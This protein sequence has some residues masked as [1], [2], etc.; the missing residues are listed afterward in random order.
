MTNTPITN[1]STL[2]TRRRVA[3]L[4]ALARRMTGHPLETWQ[5]FSTQFARVVPEAVSPA[6]LNNKLISLRLVAVLESAIKNARAF[7]PG[8]ADDVSKILLDIPRKT[9]RRQKSE[10]S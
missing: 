8:K 3:I 5:T 2:R 7:T 10:A 1:P 9:R 6:D 4:D